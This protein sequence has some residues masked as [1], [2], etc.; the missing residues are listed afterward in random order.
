MESIR[1]P[2][3]KNKKD[4]YHFMNMR[5]TGI[6]SSETHWLPNLCNSA[7]LM[8]M[9]LEEINWVGFYLVRNRALMLGPFQGKPACV[10]LEFGKGVCGTAAA[11]KQVQR[12]S[13]V[14]AFPGHVACDP[15]SRSEIVLPILVDGEVKAVLDL[16]SPV[17]SRF[18]EEDQAGLEKVVTTLA[19]HMNWEMDL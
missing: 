1:V 8:D 15:A 16:D 12:V 5:L 4:L 11:T 14:E 10:H 2:E 18:D 17:K 9:L 6:L 13:D 19:L 7:A 3:F